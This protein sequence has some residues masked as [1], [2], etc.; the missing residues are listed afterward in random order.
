MPR[1]NEIEYE[2]TFTCLLGNL[3]RFSATHE[4]EYE[5][6]FLEKKDNYSPE[7]GMYE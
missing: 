7:I 6:D 1:Y 4:Y 2:K 3:K 5:D